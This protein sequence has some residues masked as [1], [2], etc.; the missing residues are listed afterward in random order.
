MREEGRAHSLSFS[1]V[2]VALLIGPDQTCHSMSYIQ[3]KFSKPGSSTSFLCV[4]KR[5]GE[6]S[7]GGREGERREREE[8]GPGKTKETV[9]REI[10]RR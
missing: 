8:N 3:Y 2:R 6:H 9:R 5:E 7:V 10:V 1:L 4:Y